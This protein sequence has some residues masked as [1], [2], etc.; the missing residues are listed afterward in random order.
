MYTISYGLRMR[1][2]AALTQALGWSGASD[3]A[4]RLNVLDNGMGWSD[5]VSVGCQAQKRDLRAAL[6]IVQIE[7]ADAE[8]APALQA[9][10]GEIGLVSAAVQADLDRPV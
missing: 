1:L 6:G 2:A 4:F 5:T 8:A 7:A 9:L 3:L 10:R